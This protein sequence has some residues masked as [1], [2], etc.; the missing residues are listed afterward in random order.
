MLPAD[1]QD[2]LI[3]P[4]P[5][6]VGITVAGAER[7][8]VW[9]RT[10]RPEEFV[11]VAHGQVWRLPPHLAPGLANVWSRLAV[12][13]FDAK[14]VQYFD[15]HAGV[16]PATFTDFGALTLLTQHLLRQV[17]YEP[18]IPSAILL[19]SLSVF[20]HLHDG[21]YVSAT[22]VVRDSEALYRDDGVLKPFALYADQWVAARYLLD[23]MAGRG[24]VVP[25]ALAAMRS[26]ADGLLHPQWAVPIVP[27]RITTA[28]PPLHALKRTLRD[29]FTARPG[30]RWVLVQWPEVVAALASLAT[31]G[32]LRPP[33]P[34]DDWALGR[35]DVEMPLEVVTRPEVTALRRDW[36]A[37]KRSYPIPT[38]SANGVEYSAGRMAL[39]AVSA[40]TVQQLAT[41]CTAW[42]RREPVLLG[43][44]DVMPYLGSVAFQIDDRVPLP[45]LQEYF[46]HLHAFVVQPVITVGQ[47]RGQMYPIA[48]TMTQ[49][50]LDLDK[51]GVWPVECPVCHRRADNERDLVQHFKEDHPEVRR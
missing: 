8:P 22:E 32:V 31:Y 27:G 30:S 51:P 15:R 34:G 29:T 20:Q 25:D 37:R 48:D 36:L 39:E 13:S 5:V 33:Q 45:L 24:Y 40:F 18:V 3:D 50:A 44:S 35:H 1:L 47:T 6:F 23:V 2:A 41:L 26:D 7:Q 49:V 19:E 4:A 43:L 14:V 9:S 16:L 11:V 42:R 17:G 28:Q 12:I 21:V 10:F 46:Q 38:P